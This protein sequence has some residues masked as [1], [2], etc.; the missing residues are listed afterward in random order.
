VGRHNLVVESPK[1][2]VGFLDHFWSDF[3]H[4]VLYSL[5]CQAGRNTLEF[6]HRP[7]VAVDRVLVARVNLYV[8]NLAVLNAVS[9]AG[10]EQEFLV[11]DLPMSRMLLNDRPV[12]QFTKVNVINTDAS[13]E[14]RA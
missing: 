8:E 14:Q 2:F 7:H 6:E 11:A 3:R 10:W 5:L 13:L 9:R 12:I 1:R 4:C